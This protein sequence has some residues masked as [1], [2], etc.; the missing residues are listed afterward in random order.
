MP[1][2]VYGRDASGRKR[3]P[4][5]FETEEEADARRQAEEMGMIVEELEFIGPAANANEIDLRRE[6]KI[7][8]EKTLGF[9]PSADVILTSTP[10]VEGHPIKRYAGI[11]TGTATIH[12]S[13]FTIIGGRSPNYERE[14]QRACSLALAHL[15]AAALALN[16]NAVVGLQFQF[17]STSIYVTG[18]AVDVTSPTT[19]PRN[20]SDHHIKA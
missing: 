6:S 14:F 12:A 10:T 13:A 8:E 1:Y 20:V 3:D 5:F 2:W 15:E 4:L 7:G 19:A 17:E 18:T 16:A 11:V 9:R